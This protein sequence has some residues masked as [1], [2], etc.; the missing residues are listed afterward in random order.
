MT[1]FLGV[2]AIGFAFGLLG[3]LLAPVQ[4]PGRSW[5]LSALLGIC[6]ALLATYAGVAARLFDPGDWLAW[7]AAAA[8]AV[9]AL[10]LYELLRQRG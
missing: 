2:V 10:A 9:V 3:H 1:T 8:G 6:G 4:R 5:F 7:I